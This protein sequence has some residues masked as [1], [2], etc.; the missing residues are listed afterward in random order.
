MLRRHELTFETLAVRSLIEQVGTFLETEFRARHARLR[1]DVPSGVPD[2]RGDRVH[3][4]QVLLNLLLNA[5]DAVEG[6]PQE[7]RGLV[8]RAVQTAD[9]MVEFA[10]SDRGVGIPADHVPRLFDPFFT[11]KS[12][13]TG[14]GL[15]ISRTIVELHGGR[16][17][18]DDS[19]DGGATFRFTIGAAGPEAGS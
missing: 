13:G 7:R 17:W 4:Q 14:L 19:V 16:I 3:L 18:V 12:G 1:V 15:A 6:Q 11:S 2:V 8:V 9:G 5:L 10:V